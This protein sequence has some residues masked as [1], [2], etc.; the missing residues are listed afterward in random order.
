MEEKKGLTGGRKAW[1]TALRGEARAIGESTL[2]AVRLRSYSRDLDMNGADRTLVAVTA[3]H[4][5]DLAEEIERH[6]APT[7]TLQQ[8]ARAELLAL[9]TR[10]L[11]APEVTQNALEGFASSV[12]E[13]LRAEVGS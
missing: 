9:A 8:A 11:E 1:V 10:I 4:L 5:L 7:S 13:Y 6:S 3:G 12:V 2:W